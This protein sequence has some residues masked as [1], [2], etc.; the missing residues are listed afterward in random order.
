MD[1]DYPSANF[2]QCSACRSKPAWEVLRVTRSSAHPY[3][4]VGEH[5][6]FRNLFLNMLLAATV[7]KGPNFFVKLSAL[8]REVVGHTGSDPAEIAEEIHALCDVPV[9]S[10]GWLGS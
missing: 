9:A 10:E 8:L 1:F 2:L 5:E 4:G 6:S 3:D 7:G